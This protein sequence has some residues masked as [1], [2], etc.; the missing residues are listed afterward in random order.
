M[1]PETIALMEWQASRWKY[2]FSDRDMVEYLREQGV[3]VSH[4]GIWKHRQAAEW[5][6]KRSTVRPAEHPPRGKMEKVWRICL[7]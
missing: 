4:V 3:D 5:T 7:P 1:T 6:E 2:D